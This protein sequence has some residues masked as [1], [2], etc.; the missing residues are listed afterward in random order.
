MRQRVRSGSLQMHGETQCRHGTSRWVRSM[1]AEERLDA[2]TRYPFGSPDG[3]GFP[4]RRQSVTTINRTET[5]DG[6]KA[7]AVDVPS[8][9]NSRSCTFSAV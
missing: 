8:L 3:C 7:G 5:E 4:K 6:V 1:N 9:V 2:G